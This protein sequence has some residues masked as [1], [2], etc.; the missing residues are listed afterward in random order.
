GHALGTVAYMA[1]EQAAGRR[2]EVGPQS[3][4]WSIGVVLFE[5]ITGQTLFAETTAPDLVKQVE[6][7]AWDPFRTIAAGERNQVPKDLQ[8]IVLKAL[9]SL[10]SD[11][12]QSAGDMAEDLS[13]FCHGQPI[14]AR[15]LTALERLMRWTARNRAMAGSVLAIAA[16]SL[17]ALLTVMTVYSAILSSRAR[18]LAQAVDDKEVAV[19]DALAA[20]SLAKRREQDAIEL[21]RRAEASELAT[22]KLSYRQGMQ[23]ASDQLAE[24][25]LTRAR[26]LLLQQVPAKDEPDVRGFEWELL[27]AE[28]R[29]RVHYFGHHGGAAAEVAVFQNGRLA[30]TVGEDGRVKI[31]DLAEEALIREFDPQLGPLHAVAVTPDGSKLAIGNMANP[32]NGDVSQVYLLDAQTGDVLRTLHRHATTIESIAISSDGQWI[33]SGSR[34]RNVIVTDLQGNNEFTI[35]TGSR[36]R[37]TSVRFSPNSKRIA[38]VCYD[39]ETPELQIWDVRGKRHAISLRPSMGNAP[40]DFCWRNDETMVISDAWNIEIWLIEKSEQLVFYSLPGGGDGGRFVQLVII[41]GDNDTQMVATD[42]NGDVYLWSN[43]FSMWER[44]PD[45]QL[46]VHSDKVTDL[47]LAGSSHLLTTCNDGSIAMLSAWGRPW[48]IRP[49]NFVTTSASYDAATKSFFLGTRQGEIYRHDAQGTWSRIYGPSGNQTEDLAV[50]PGRNTLAVVDE[51]GT[52]SLVDSRSGQLIK[53]FEQQNQVGRYRLSSSENGKRLAVVGTDRRL[54]VFDPESQTQLSSLDIQRESSDLCCSPDGRRV[55]VGYG[56][57][58]IY[59]TETGSKVREIRGGG[60]PNTSLCY[61]PSGRILASGHTEGVIRIT[62]LDSETT[63]VRRVPYEPSRTMHFVS[64]GEGLLTMDS[65][66]DR[67]HVLDVATGESL[68]STP[69]IARDFSS[70]D[71]ELGTDRIIMFNGRQGDTGFLEWPLSEPKETLWKRSRQHDMAMDT[72]PVHAPLAADQTIALQNVMVSVVNYGLQGSSPPEAT[73]PAEYF[74]GI[75]WKLAHNSAGSQTFERANPGT[76]SDAAVFLDGDLVTRRVQLTNS[77]E[78]P[79]NG[80]GWYV[81]YVPGEQ[82]TVVMECVHLD[83]QT[84][85]YVLGVTAQ[86]QVEL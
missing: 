34:Y 80:R 36:S 47:T 53:R 1:P 70:Y 6:F 50:V 82:Y 18:E 22:R 54:R 44:S 43:R 33:A 13:L 31:W 48:T 42:L 69:R 21:R 46:G 10:P 67:F 73:M 79:F 29:S 24:G 37:N 78:P 75:L 59:D 56:D 84:T 8:T 28:L 5:M 51:L 57:V 30:A 66:T 65:K 11:R 26:E 19:K 63:I 17:F 49:T 64:D 72:N 85:H 14:K 27:N 25:H 71:F 58:A 4:V 35:P 15:R 52:V 39:G 60:G 83:M 20:E 23:N 41:D 7:S 32:S 55:A 76:P 86:G 2:R 61:H 9:A 40:R 62:D 74:N 81:H 16:V 38:A 68:G 45:L 3:D 12:Y 77:P